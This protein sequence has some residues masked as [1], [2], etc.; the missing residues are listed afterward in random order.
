MIWQKE[1]EYN[2]FAS[3]THNPS[4]TQLV[5]MYKCDHLFKN[6][7]PLQQIEP[8]TGAGCFYETTYSTMIDLLLF[9]NNAWAI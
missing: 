6:F 1:V 8:K 5:Y 4:Q 2:F 9:C 7:D 3:D